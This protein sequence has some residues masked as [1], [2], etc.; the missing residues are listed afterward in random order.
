MY[1]ILHKSVVIQD[2]SVHVLFN[3]LLAELPAI[4]DNLSIPQLATLGWSVGGDGELRKWQA[5]H[6]SRNH[7]KM[8]LFVL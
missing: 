8:G 5:K 1:T 3:G 4:L 7:F 6:T 2:N